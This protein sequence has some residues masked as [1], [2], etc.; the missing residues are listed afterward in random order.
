MKFTTKTGRKVVGALVAAAVM[1]SMIPAMVFAADP[2][3]KT[4]V[5]SPTS[6]QSKTS[7]SFDGINITA[8]GGSFRKSQNSSNRYLE[9]SYG[10]DSATFTF[11]ID[12]SGI[13]KG[14]QITKIEIA[15]YDATGIRSNSWG[16][17]TWTAGAN[18]TASVSLQLTKSNGGGNHRVTFSSITVYVTVPV[19]SAT[20]SNLDLVKGDAATEMTVTLLPT[21]TTY[22]AADLTYTSSAESVAT[23]AVSDGKVM[24]T[25]VGGGSTT[26]TAYLGSK[27]L[28][29][30][31]VNVAVPATSATI[32][33]LNL[34]LSDSATALT[35]TLGPSYTTYTVADLT[36]KSS[37]EG[38]AT[39]AVSDGKVMVTP[40]GLGSTTITASSGTTALGSA[41][42]SVYSD[43]QL[44]VNI[45][46]ST[47]SLAPDGDTAT[48]SYTVSGATDHN[49]V[50]D[51]YYSNDESIATVDDS[52]LVTSVGIG[53]TTIEVWIYDKTDGTFVH[54]DCA[55]TVSE[56]PAPD[57]E[58]DPEPDVPFYTEE[59]LRAMSVQNFVEGMYVT[60]LNR[61]FD[62][63]GRDSWMN[64][65]L[66]QNGTATA[67]AIGFLESP[68]FT[69][70]NVSD[71]EFVATCYR[72]FCNRAA[73]SAET[74]SWVTQ[75]E[76]G[77]SRDSVIRQFAQSP[78]WANIC[79]FF[80]VNV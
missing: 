44:V 6:T 79:A 34:H 15:G 17:S 80:K 29:T 27:S 68:E 18:P 11:A 46:P 39:V 59:Q 32:G 4:A 76:A 64:L 42:V 37:E 70:Y 78:E 7:D 77:T 72:V 50:F 62:A 10:N 67:V 24:V 35:V 28:G 19:T 54:S 63:A 41:T 36:W 65:I 69:S 74:A 5:F 73:T 61:Q 14:G 49:W 9:F 55:V 58:P 47:L 57:P 21:T 45:S 25:P 75:L 51:E 8:S 31:T 3:V 2:G 33:D 1:V 38:V 60:I 40:V 53:E 23:V 56:N 66:E 26:I 12:Q 16:G 71:E 13:Y 30:A 43:D 52:G 20:L 48:L 22:T